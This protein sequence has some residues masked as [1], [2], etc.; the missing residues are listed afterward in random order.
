VTN[1][2]KRHERLGLLRIDVPGDVAEHLRGRIDTVRRL[3]IG[4][5]CERL[6]IDNLV[7]SVD[8]FGL[9]CY[10]QGLMDASNPVIRAAVETLY[11]E[12]TTP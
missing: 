8:A 9:D 2:K 1:P 11:S 6:S 12:V 4:F 3:H 5:G 10:I 7:Q